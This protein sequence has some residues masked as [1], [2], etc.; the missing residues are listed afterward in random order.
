VK[1][2]ALLDTG[3]QARAQDEAGERE[4]AQRM[5]LVELA[6]EE[7]M[8]AMGRRWV[9]PMVHPDRLDDAAF[10]AAILDM[11]ERKTVDVF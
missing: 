4:R 3:W 9:R 1:A 6:R 7:G 2:L 5:G 10:M 11:I 8:R